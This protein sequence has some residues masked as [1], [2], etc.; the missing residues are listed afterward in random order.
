MG[1]T[2][3]LWSFGDGMTDAVNANPVHLYGANGSY[4]V[5]LTTHNSISG[6]ADT[7]ISPITLSSPVAGIAVTDTALCRGDTVTMVGSLSAAPVGAARSYS[8]YLDNNSYV[9]TTGT[10]SYSYHTIGQKPVILVIGDYR[11]CNDTAYRTLLIAHPTAQ[12][13]GSPTP[14]CSPMPVLFNDQ[15]TD[16]PTTYYTAHKWDLGDGTVL[17]GNASSV[18]HGYSSAGSFTVKLYVTDNIGC[19]DT[20]VKP[21]FIV[22]HK[23]IAFFSTATTACQNRAVTFNNTS[24]GSNLTYS[25]SFGDGGSSTLQAP[26]HFYMNTGTY[27]VS[28]VVTDDLGC[29]DTLIRSNYVTVVADPVAAFIASDTFS[30]CSPL[31]DTFTNFSTGGIS[32][33][34]SFG[35]GNTSAFFNTSNPYTTP[36]Q[37]NVRLVVTNTY[38]CTDTATV[39][40][41]LLGYAGVL[42]YSPTSGCVP[43]TVTFNANVTGVP[44]FTYDFSDGNTFTTSSATTT[45]TYTVAGPH[46]PRLVLSNSRCQA[47]SAGID[48]IKVDGITPGFKTIPNPI[49]GADTVQF[50]DTSKAYFTPITSEKWI[51]NNGATSTLPS[52]VHYYIPGSYNVSLIATSGSGCVDTFLSTIVVHPIPVISA[53]TDTTI[54]KSDSAQLLPSGGVSYVWSP[55][56]LLSCSACTMPRTAPS[57]PTVYYVVGTDVYGCTNT[58]SV[59]VRIK[60]KATGTADTGGD[61]CITGSLQLFAHDSFA[62]AQ[63][64]WLPANGLSNNLIADPFAKPDTST[65]YMVII[66]EG[67]CIPDTAYVQVNVHPLPVIS[68]APGQTILAGSSVQLQTTETNVTRYLWQPPDGLDCDTCADPLATPK[69]TTLYQVFGYTDFGCVDSARINIDVVCDHSQVF[70]P[71]TFTPNNDGANDRFYPR[72]KGLQII[73]SFRIYDRWGQKIYEKDNMQLNDM[74]NGWD[75]TFKNAKLTPDV[76]VYVVDAICDTGSPITWTGDITLLR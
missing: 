72:G 11:G 55:S 52:P 49:C 46:V 3:F 8:W 27:T 38:G 31:I 58:D 62:N 65:R 33:A 74:S 20:L 48:T 18:S 64:L 53:G 6:C 29:K 63:Y 56:A 40:V 17:S 15:S 36:G 47:Y 23:P 19:S 39:L 2:S 14:V 21:A 34:W 67:K 30:I 66:K 35:D 70:M 75:G 44:S 69:R 51:F 13:T 60:L 73:R 71:N 25:W 32:Y 37:Y 42:T 50:V 1:A 16:A 7:A 9:D 41:K 54:C 45:H 10:F 59:T 5:M 12:F 57:V 26:V 24:T 28:L 68:A 22:V 61:L 43:L 4:T 76:Y